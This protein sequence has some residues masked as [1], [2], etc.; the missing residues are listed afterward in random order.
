LQY[1]VVYNVIDDD[2]M[3]LCEKDSL[4]NTGHAPSATVVFKG[5]CW[6]AIDLAKGFGKYVIQ[7]P[8]SGVANTQAAFCLQG[9]FVQPAMLFGNLKIISIYVI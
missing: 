2:T 5:L 8:K 9:R 1:I 4:L 7:H 3:L 6:C